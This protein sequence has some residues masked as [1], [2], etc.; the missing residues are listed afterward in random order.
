MERLPAWLRVILGVLA[1]FMSVGLFFGALITAGMRFMNASLGRMT[2]ADIPAIAA[3]AGLLVLGIGCF[4]LARRLLPSA[5]PRKDTVAKAPGSAG[6]A[7]FATPLGSFLVLTVGQF[8]FMGHVFLRLDLPAELAAGLLG[9]ALALVIYRDDRALRQR[10]GEQA[11][12]GVADP[13]AAPGP[14]QP[15]PE[16]AA[17]L[18]LALPVVA[19][20]LIWQQRFFH[21][22][23]RGAI[24]VLF[25]AVVGT[26]VLGY[27]DA[28]QIL[29]RSPA[30][31]TPAGPMRIQPRVHF[32]MILWFWIVG[33]P[34]HFIGRRNHGARNLVAPAVAAMAV[35]VLLAG[36]LGFRSAGPALPA[37]N[38][39]QVAAL[40]EKALIESPGYQANKELFGPVQVRDLVELSFDEK[41]QRRVG[42]GVLFS[43]VGWKPVF[44]SVEWQDRRQGRFIIRFA[45]APYALSPE[46]PR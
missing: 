25:A 7:F 9:L 19:G 46:A 15:A 3:V 34:V 17:M 8:M 20:V 21:L 6:Y 36:F 30:V 35:G 33:Y 26:A 42:Q 27:V 24:L 43:K 1:V 5:A 14:T 37:V 16:T 13:G 10:V 23:D 18:M 40:V 45:E 39:P 31:Q 44:F 32:S 38:S 29:L 41:N 4:L 12:A 11:Q 28:R 2:A 22:S